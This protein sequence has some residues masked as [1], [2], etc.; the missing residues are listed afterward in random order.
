[1]VVRM[2]AL[3]ILARKHISMSAG[4]WLL[5]PVMAAAVPVA[6]Y[7]PPPCGCDEDEEAIISPVCVKICLLRSDRSDRLDDRFSR[8]T[9]SSKI[10]SHSLIIRSAFHHRIFV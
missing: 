1:M 3:L 2:R 7:E 10:L 9:F 4:C 6:L 5:V 8:I